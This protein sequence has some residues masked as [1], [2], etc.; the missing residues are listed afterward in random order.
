MFR[1]NRK[2]LAV[3]SADQGD[4]PNSFQD[5][6]VPKEIPD[7]FQRPEKCHA[8]FMKPSISSQSSSWYTNSWKIS[9]KQILLKNV[10]KK[11][12]PIIW[13]TEHKAPLLSVDRRTPHESHDDLQLSTH[14]RLYVLTTKTKLQL[15]PTTEK[16]CLSFG[17]QMFEKHSQHV[18][19]VGWSW[20]IEVTWYC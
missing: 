11:F 14:T 6:L 5:N 16:R 19:P 15:N 13:V 1:I 17:Q 9:K 8:T 10:P 7:S 3:M 12:G 4:Q 18:T 2:S 20:R